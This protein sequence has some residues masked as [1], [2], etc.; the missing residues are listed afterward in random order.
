MDLTSGDFTDLYGDS[1]GDFMDLGGDSIYLGD[2][3][4]FLELLA[5]SYKSSGTSLAVFGIL[6]V[7]ISMIFSCMNYR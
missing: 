3:M 4:P 7:D 6:F 2:K 1:K 5:M